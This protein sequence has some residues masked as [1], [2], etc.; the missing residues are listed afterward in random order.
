MTLLAP[1]EVLLMVGACASA[2]LWLGFPIGVAAVTVVA[3]GIARGLPRGLKV[4]P[5]QVLSVTGSGATGDTA[6]W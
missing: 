1:L 3:V 5:T 6:E 2:P 4:T